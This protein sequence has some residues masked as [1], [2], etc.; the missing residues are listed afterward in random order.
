[1]SHH[2][3][4][5]CYYFSPFPIAIQPIQGFS[6]PAIASPALHSDPIMLEPS[7]PESSL[8]EPS[9]FTPLTDTDLQIEKM[10]GLGALITGVAHEI[11]NPVN[12]IHGNLNYAD[13]Y[14]QELIRLIGLYRQAFPEGTPEIQHQIEQMDLEF[15][16]ED[17][18]KIQASMQLGA[19]RIYEIVQSLRT[20]SHTDEQNY[21][22]FNLHEGIDSTLTILHH[23]LKGNGDR[24]AIQVEKQYGDLPAIECY[25]GRLNQVMMNLLSNA[26]DAIETQIQEPFSQEPFSPTKPPDW[27]PK[28]TI[29]TQREVDQ[30][31]VVIQDNGCGMTP[32]V[33]AQIFKP[34]FTT[35][36]V[37][38]GSGL[39]LSICDRIITQ[40]HGGQIECQSQ[41]GEGTYFKFWVPVEQK[42]GAAD[43]SILMGTIGADLG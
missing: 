33:A 35:K 6:N 10:A 14:L 42:V 37:R 34:F 22:R 29:T 11:N 13:R 21:Q 17:F 5:T 36:G 24:P 38:Q 26:I 43:G 27:Q 3:P 30:I 32:E 41:L 31:A 19:N 28:I 2:I 20:F 8:P 9:S 23:R 25:A 7:L 12:F 15:V 18:P 1:M 39:G 4:S 40:D 16:L